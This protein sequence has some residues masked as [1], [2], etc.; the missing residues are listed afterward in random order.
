M[1]RFFIFAVTLSIPASLIYLN[2]TH[3]N[4]QGGL[5]FSIFVILAAVERV[6][7]TF[8][9]PKDKDVRK[10]RGDWS[11][12]VTSFL[13]LIVSL[14]IIFT[15]F[16]TNSKNNLVLVIGIIIYLSAI[17]LRAWS[18]GLLKNQWSIHLTDNPKDKEKKLIKSGPYR[19][20]RH[21]IYLGA[22]LDLIGF[23]LIA[24]A[25]YYIFV[26]LFVN[27]P[28]YIWRCFEDEK[29]STEKF[30]KEYIE[31]KKTT[32]PLIPFKLFKK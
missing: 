28:F 4:V 11:L 5:L 15:F 30:G 22:I 9:T 3:P 20:I 29:I 27:T 17:A 6:W 24:N 13:Y 12:I 2:I 21:P 23:A 7:E 10:F 32:S 25:Y 26:I 1:I 16:S 8:Y 14:L 19:Y 31:Y 18:I